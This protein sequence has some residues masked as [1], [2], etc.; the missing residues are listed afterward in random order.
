MQIDNETI[1]AEEQNRIT[2]EIAEK[3][4]I[5]NYQNKVTDMVMG[6]KIKLCPKEITGKQRQELI[7]KPSTGKRMLMSLT[8]TALSQLSSKVNK[9][10]IYDFLNAAGFTHK[11]GCFGLFENQ[12]LTGSDFSNSIIVGI[13]FR[14]S[15]LTVAN[16]SNSI[17]DHTSFKDTDLRYTNI[18]GAYLAL[19][20]DLTQKQINQTALRNAGTHLPRGLIKPEKWVNA[21]KQKNLEEEAEDLQRE[22]DGYTK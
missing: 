8:T 16:L 14:R 19:A 1:R 7:P 12:R 20:T 11:K 17:F 5:S 3:T 22:I 10:A 15:R 2:T 9:R 18:S 6:G 13:S 21:L 4:I